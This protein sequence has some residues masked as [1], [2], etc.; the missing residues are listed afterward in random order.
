LLDSLD[1]SLAKKHQVLLLLLLSLPGEFFI[2]IGWV[3]G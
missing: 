1:K 2:T 3:G